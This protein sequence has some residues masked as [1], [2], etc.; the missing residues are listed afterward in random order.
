MLDID[1]IEVAIYAFCMDC[2]LS[3]G[4]KDGLLLLETAGLVVLLVLRL[5]MRLQIGA[6]NSLLSSTHSVIC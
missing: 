5:C 2:P 1:V 6:A 3:K 4:A